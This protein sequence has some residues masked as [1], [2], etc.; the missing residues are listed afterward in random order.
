MSE[1]DLTNPAVA[2]YERIAEKHKSNEMR[3]LNKKLR[4]LQ[5]KRARAAQQIRELDREIVIVN[6]EVLKVIRSLIKENE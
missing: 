6:I 4:G 1:R 3:L 5:N 2:V